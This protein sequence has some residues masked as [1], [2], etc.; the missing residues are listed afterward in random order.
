MLRFGGSAK[1]W[2]YYSRAEGSATAAKT[3]HLHPW[4]LTSTLET[5]APR[6]NRLHARPRQS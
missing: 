5:D 6:K 2:A 3:R 1:T 4:K